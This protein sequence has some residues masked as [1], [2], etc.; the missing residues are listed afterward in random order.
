MEAATG[1][2]CQPSRNNEVLEDKKETFL[3]GFLLR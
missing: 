2:L 3:L 1:G